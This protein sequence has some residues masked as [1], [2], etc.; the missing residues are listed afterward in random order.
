MFNKKVLQPVY[1]YKNKAVDGVGERE[2]ERERLG[3]VKR[4][5]SSRIKQFILDQRSHYLLLVICK[6]ISDL[7]HKVF[8]TLAN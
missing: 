7:F 8:W 1:V 2:G 3:R 6:Y 5:F 4:T